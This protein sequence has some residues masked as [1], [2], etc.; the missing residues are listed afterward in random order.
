MVSL[1]E[2]EICHPSLN[3]VIFHENIRVRYVISNDNL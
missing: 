2:V 1:C 3:N